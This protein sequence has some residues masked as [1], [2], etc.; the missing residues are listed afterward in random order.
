MTA[1]G[2]SWLRSLDSKSLEGLEK[3]LKT[4]LTDGDDTS[5]F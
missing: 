2:T 1:T 3:L 4:L 5:M